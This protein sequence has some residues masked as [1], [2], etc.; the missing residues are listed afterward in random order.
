[1][2]TVERVSGKFVDSEIGKKGVSFCKRSEVWNC[3]K[4]WL[5]LI[6]W[7]HVKKKGHV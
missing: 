4:D 1:M 5:E 7:D 3:E 2:W 6:A